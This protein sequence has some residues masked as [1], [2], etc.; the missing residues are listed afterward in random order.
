MQ[1][2][3][4]ATQAKKQVSEDRRKRKALEAERSARQQAEIDALGPAPL[5]GRR[6]MDVQTDTY[7][8]VLIDREPEEEIGVQTDA[9]LDRPPSPLFIPRSVRTRTEH[10]R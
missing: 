7:L 8:E 10:E 9:A 1:S 3:L 5:D 4:S 2:V 6:H